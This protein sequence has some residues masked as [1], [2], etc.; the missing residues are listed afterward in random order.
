MMGRY[1]PQHLFNGLVVKYLMCD[2]ANTSDVFDTLIG[3][4]TE[5]YPD[6]RTSDLVEDVMA[7]ANEGRYVIRVLVDAPNSPYGTPIAALE[8]VMDAFT[9]AIAVEKPLWRRMAEDYFFNV[10]RSPIPNRVEKA[11][12]HLLAAERV[13]MARMAPAE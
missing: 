5:K 11:K 12:E 9:T 4:Y 1:I 3:N 8:G 2:E 7:A 6:E 10:Q 13:L